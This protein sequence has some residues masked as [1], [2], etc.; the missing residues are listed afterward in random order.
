MAKFLVRKPEI[1][2]ASYIVEADDEKEAMQIVK[3]NCYDERCEEIEFEYSH[4]MDTDLWDV[5]VYKEYNL[6]K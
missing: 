5:D 2:I 4:T 1:H 3:N 6:K